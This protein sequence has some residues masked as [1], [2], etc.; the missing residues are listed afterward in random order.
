MRELANARIGVVGLGYVGLPLAVEFGR[1]YDTL[2]F[3]ID[4]ARVEALRRGRDGNR[5]V[6]GEELATATRLRLSADAADLRDRDVY[7]V[8]VPTPINE[9]KQPDFGPLVRASRSIGATLK[10]GDIVVYESTVY[11]G[12]TEEI[13]V[14]ELERASGLRCNADFTVG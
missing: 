4:A 2:G 5:E 3:D 14:P 1:H 11:P 7:I 12:A 6:D 9:H 13:C 8:T 10:R